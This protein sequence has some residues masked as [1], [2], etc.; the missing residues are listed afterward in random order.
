MFAP[1]QKQPSGA[2]LF[3][4]CKVDVGAVLQPDSLLAKSIKPFVRSALA[5][6][7]CGT[8]CA[9]LAWKVQAPAQV[10]IAKC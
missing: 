3:V 7:V 8:G 6:P 9:S 4:A 5:C 1:S 2:A 10:P